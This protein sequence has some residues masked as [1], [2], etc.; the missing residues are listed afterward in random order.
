LQTFPAAPPQWRI[1][2]LPS[3]DS[4]QDGHPEDKFT[5]VQPWRGEISVL[6][7]P[8]VAAAAAA[9]VA[10]EAMEIT[11]ALAAVLRQA[12]MHTRRGLE[13]GSRRAYYS[14][15]DEFVQSLNMI[16][17]ALDAEQQSMRH[18]LALA[19]GLRAL[20]ESDDFARHS[21]ALAA[22]VNVQEIAALHRTPVVR[23]AQQPMSPL[24][25]LQQYYTFA[26]QQLADSVDHLPAGSVALTSLG[27]LY[28]VAATDPTS[29]LLSPE[30]KA[31]TLHQA[32][33]V[34]DRRNA[35]AANELGVLL[36]RY[37]RYDDALA[38][39]Q[40]SAAIAPQPATWHNLA[41]VHQTLGQTQLADAARKRQVAM[42]PGGSRDL[43]SRAPEIRWVSVNEFAATSGGTLAA[44]GAQR[45]ATRAADGAQPPATMGSR[46]NTPSAEGAPRTH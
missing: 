19:A 30:S 43:K 38:W 22:D 39:L 41:V 10:P 5:A 20:D 4:E 31:M 14:A 33:L 25:A 45:S 42:S 40:H 24:G 21:T 11:P 15:R 46:Q 9:E 8:K 1:E 44:P 26:Q 7:L 23:E 16:S 28:S 32:A 17:Q 18:S 12:D 36:A 3:T 37:G 27:K 6:P 34:V 29:K 35:V 2:P 13:L